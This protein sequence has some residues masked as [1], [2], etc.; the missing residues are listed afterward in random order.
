MVRAGRAG[1]VPRWRRIVPWV[2]IVVA[3]IIALAGAMNVWVKRQALD[4]DNWVSTSSQLLEDDQV[5]QALSVYLVDQLYSNVDVT[6][7]L[8]QRLPDDFE[9]LAAPLASALQVAAVRGADELLGRPRAQEAWKNANQAAHTLFLAVIDNE[10][11]RL[12]TTGDKVVLD[13]RPLVQELTQRQGLIGQAA[14]RIPPD[15]GQLVIMDS[16]QLDT[17]Q[18]AV[19]VIE[20]MSYFLGILVLVLYA[21]AVYLARGARRS[22][23][24]GVGF[25]VMIVGIVMFA[26]LRFAG[27]WLVDA[28]TSNPDFKEATQAT[29]SIGTQLLRNTAT[30]FVAYGSRSS[31]L[32][33]SPA[34]R[35]RP[36][37]RRCWPVSSLRD[38]PSSLHCAAD[39]W[40]AVSHPS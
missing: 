15:A 1:R 5:R 7:E 3:T 37:A 26:V 40:S 6:A 39:A 38:V 22:T 4:T 2:L 19:R 30:S 17:A 27:N 18:T 34:P 23:L 25:G 8:Q 9:G 29:W 10:S 11:E 21:L 31:P 36:L 32:R 14:Q 24:M 20:A 13:L 12:Q 16:T 33:G 35:E 28:L